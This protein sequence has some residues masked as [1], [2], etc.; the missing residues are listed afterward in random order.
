MT[1]S[2]FGYGTLEIPLVMQ[3]VTGKSF[4][5]T[6]AVLSDHARFLLQGETYPGIF[7]N[8]GSRVTGILYEEVDRDS[9]AVLDLFE[10]NF[11]RRERVQVTTPSRPRVDAYT[12]VVPAEHRPL[13]ST[14][15]WD[16]EAF[17]SRH[18]EDFLP[19]CREFHRDQTRRL[20][21]GLGSR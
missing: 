17:I 14:Q 8:H 1:S 11:F 7:P 19:Y 6:A 3:A 5:R 16:R 12:Y 15:P 21:M 20:G 2:L 9:L 10:G 18:L 13:F 4:R